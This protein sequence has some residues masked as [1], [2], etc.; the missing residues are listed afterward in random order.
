MIDKVTPT[1]LDANATVRRLPNKPKIKEVAVLDLAD[2]I[3][4]VEVPKVGIRTSISMPPMPSTYTVE[5]GTHFFYYFLKNE[6]TV[7]MLNGW[8]RLI[9]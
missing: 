4:V 6:Q 9:N 1:F 3:V 8:N 7:R 2:N 5:N